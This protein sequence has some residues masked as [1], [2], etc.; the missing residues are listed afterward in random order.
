MFA[1]GARPSWVAC[2]AAGLI[3]F[4]MLLVVWWFGERCLHLVLVRGGL[5]A[6]PQVSSFFTCYWLCGGLV[7]GVCTCGL[8]CGG[9]GAEVSH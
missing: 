6:G 3:F 1:L 2:R 8:V 5:H 9:V 4:H 7:S